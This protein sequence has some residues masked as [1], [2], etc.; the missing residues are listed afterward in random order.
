MGK[1]SIKYQIMLISRELFEIK[2]FD[3]HAVL[4]FILRND[5]R[6]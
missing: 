3:I 2:S 5:Q 4:G 1:V 6:T